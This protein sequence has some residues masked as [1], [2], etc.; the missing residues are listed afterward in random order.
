MA[1]PPAA[2]RHPACVSLTQIYGAAT[3]GPGPKG[4]LAGPGT[5]R[6]P[7]SHLFVT[8]RF[9]IQ[10]FCTFAARLYAEFRRGSRQIGPAPSILICFDHFLKNNEC[11]T[12]FRK[13]RA[14]LTGKKRPCEERRSWS[15]GVWKKQ[16][17]AWLGWLACCALPWLGL[18]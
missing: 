2:R 6:D 4:V 13:Y 11:L 18:A 8:N 9:T 7:K 3:Q 5:P 10:P 12:H 16:K 15:N 14:F 1:R 17:L